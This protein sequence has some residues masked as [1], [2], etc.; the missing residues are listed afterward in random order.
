MDLIAVRPELNLYDAGWPV[1]TL[2]HQLPC[3]KTVWNEPDRRGEVLQSL[4]ANGSIVSGGRVERSILSSR[5]RVNS[6]AEVVDSILFEGVSVG[7]R[8]RVQRAIV[9]KGVRI[10]EGYR[11]G[12]DREQDERRFRV[13]DTGI[14]VVAKEQ[15]L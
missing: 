11:I 2:Q 6:F 13:T 4:I 1:H 8:A 9:D 7:R 3:A 14:T 5:V 10:P 15:V 12:C